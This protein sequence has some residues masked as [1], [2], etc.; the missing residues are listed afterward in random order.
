M[1]KNPLVSGPVVIDR[2]ATS[3]SNQGRHFYVNGGNLEMEGVTLTGGYTT[4]SFFCCIFF[5]LC[6]GAYVVLRFFG[7]GGWC[8]TFV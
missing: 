8:G 2:Q 3:G 6:L 4:V 5:Y 1:K 7:V